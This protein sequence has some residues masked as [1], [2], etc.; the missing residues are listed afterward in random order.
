MLTHNEY[1]EQIFDVLRF[2][3]DLACS[4]QNWSNVSRDALA[5]GFTQTDVSTAFAYAQ[6]FD[7]FVEPT[8]FISL[9]YRSFDPSGP[10]RALPAVSKF[11]LTMSV[12]D[13]IVRAH[14]NGFDEPMPSKDPAVWGELSF[15]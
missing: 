11:E 10:F 15:T 2:S 4:E 5:F 13:E 6:R 3:I 1:A 8:I 7:L 9:H 12:G 14:Q